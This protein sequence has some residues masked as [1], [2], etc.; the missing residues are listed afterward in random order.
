VLCDKWNASDLKEQR[1]SGPAVL[2]SSFEGG[3]RKP[4]DIGFFGE[5]DAHCRASGVYLPLHI[6]PS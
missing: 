4:F 5:T 1:P 3:E 6:M 2:L